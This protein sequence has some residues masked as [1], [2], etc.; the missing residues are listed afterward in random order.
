MLWYGISEIVERIPR[1]EEEEMSIKSKVKMLPPLLTKLNAIRL[2]FR[3]NKRLNR[4]GN[5]TNTICK[6]SKVYT[7]IIL[8][9]WQR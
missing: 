7:I 3:I 5:E 8:K 4:E 6:E 1:A 9:Q 2:V